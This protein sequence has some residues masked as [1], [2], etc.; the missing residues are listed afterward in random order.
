[1]LKRN[2]GVRVIRRN[3]GFSMVELL[4]VMAITVFVLAAASRILVALMTQFKQQTKI[5]E[6][7]IE[8]QVGL[9]IMRTDLKT[10][11]YG[12]PWE[13]GL[14]YTEAVSFGTP[15]A[16]DYNDGGTTPPKAMESGNNDV[17]IG[18]TGL[19][20]D[21]LVLKSIMVASS[22]GVEAAGKWHSYTIESDLVTEHVNRWQ[23]ETSGDNLLVTDKVVVHSLIGNVALED[24]GADFFTTFD[25]VNTPG[26]A[27][28]PS[29]RDDV[30]IIYG[31]TGGVDPR[32]PFNRADYYISY[33]N[34]PIRCAPNSGVLVKAILS[35]TDG[36]LEDELPL[37]DC[38]VD[39]QVTYWLDTTGNGA[40]DDIVNDLSGKIASDLR[41][42]LKE[43]RVY[44]LAH[45]G[46]R[47]P[48][49][50]FSVKADGTTREAV[51]NITESAD[52]ASNTVVLANLK[53]VV[54]DPVYKFF[55]WRVFRIS[56]A[57]TS[58]R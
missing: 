13:L 12:L 33:S 11:G 52:L 18:A 46:Q 41:D 48:M 49:Y 17:P 6:T 43:V 29:A 37:L 24:D 34:V 28:A 39:M 20:S 44:L 7:N 45:E 21:Y 54:G 9:E 31:V 1:L 15:N 3:E 23:P 40:V 16:Q 14:P 51:D 47:D 10:A 19:F 22:A 8:S 35:H 55:R 4:V 30:R 42:E 27:F 53:T 5:A 56:E 32:M 25:V 2:R 50:D 36:K 57:P 26:S 38:V 58:L